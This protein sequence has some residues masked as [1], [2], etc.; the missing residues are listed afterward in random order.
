L[1]REGFLSRASLH[2]LESFIWCFACRVKRIRI[3][4]YCSRITRRT[5]RGQWK[6]WS[7]IGSLPTRAP[8][9]IC[10]AA[11]W[12]CGKPM[13][14]V[15]HWALFE[16]F[17]PWLSVAT[18]LIGTDPHHS[19]RWFS[20][21]LLKLPSSFPPLWLWGYGCFLKKVKR[22]ELLQMCASSMN[23]P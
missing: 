3:L 10:R 8:Y 1:E 17:P 11:P 9:S 23:E 7:W 16:G 20:R 19:T 5:V 18:P 4:V 21:E 2:D 12:G 22:V 15:E 13:S 6:T 14:W